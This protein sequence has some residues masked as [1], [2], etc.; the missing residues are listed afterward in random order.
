MSLCR[1]LHGSTWVCMEV[2]TGLLK[3]LYRWSK[4]RSM[5]STHR[6]IWTS[7]QIYMEVYMGLCGGLLGCMQ[8]SMCV[9]IEVCAEVY[10]SLCVDF[11]RLF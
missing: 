2:Y 9:Y 11:S 8:R 10:V 7:M 6:S 4:W 3:G 5:G 1:G